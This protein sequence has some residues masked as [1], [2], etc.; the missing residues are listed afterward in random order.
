MLAAL[1]L[2]A[3]YATQ[4][5][6]ILVLARSM[7]L[8]TYASGRSKASRLIRE[9]MNASDNVWANVDRTERE[10]YVFLRLHIAWLIT[11]LIFLQN[12]FEI[13]IG[14]VFCFFLIYVSVSCFLFVSYF[15]HEKKVIEGNL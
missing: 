15:N 3:Q 13:F 7:V 8:H 4:T 9:D 5:L 11:W 12:S 2:Q 1:K 10:I 14:V 6:P